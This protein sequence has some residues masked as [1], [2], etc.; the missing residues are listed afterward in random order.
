MTRHI[1]W[2]K[3]CCQQGKAVT[4]SQKKDMMDNSKITICLTHICGKV[5]SGDLVTSNLNSWST[6]GIQAMKRKKNKT[7]I[8]LKPL[9]SVSAASSCQMTLIKQIRN[10]TSEGR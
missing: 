1:V 7:Q 9:S 5:C 2:L 6:V 4:T 3:L 10:V 8:F